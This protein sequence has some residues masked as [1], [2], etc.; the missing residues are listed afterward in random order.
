[1]GQP[2][3]VNPLKFLGHCP[4]VGFGISPMA[5][6]AQT[7]AKNGSQYDKSTLPDITISV[8]HQ[9]VKE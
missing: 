6:Q 1:M 9:Y 7:A 4:T 2:F 8:L 5:L 3:A